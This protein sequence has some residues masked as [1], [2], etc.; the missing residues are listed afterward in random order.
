MV[1]LESRFFMLI[2]G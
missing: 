2:L 1:Y